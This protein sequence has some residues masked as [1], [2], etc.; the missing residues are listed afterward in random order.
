MLFISHDLSVVRVLA[1]R[2]AV[3]YGGRILEL[4]G[5]GSLF[6][7]PLQPYT[8]ELLAA[9]RNPIRRWQNIATN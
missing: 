4:A 2:V 7:H 8:Q 6:E 1:D 5:T 9:I 3:M